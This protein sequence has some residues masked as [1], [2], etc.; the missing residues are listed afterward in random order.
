MSVLPPW[1]AGVLV[2][3]SIECWSEGGVSVLPPLECWS[4]GEGVV[5]VLPWKTNYTWNLRSIITIIIIIIFPLSRCV[6]VKTKLI[7]VMY[8]CTHFKFLTKLITLTVVAGHYQGL[9]N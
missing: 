4:A 9:S 3:P 7:N 1:S 2:L 6:I 5:S 8:T